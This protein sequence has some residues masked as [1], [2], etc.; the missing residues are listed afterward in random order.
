MSKIISGI[1]K[2]ENL[3]NGKIYIG[4]TCNFKQRKSDHYKTLRGNKHDNPHLQNAWNKYGEKNFKFE[5]VEYVE[6]I[7]ESLVEREQYWINKLNVC[8]RDK[9][10]NILPIAGTT[11]GRVVSEET[12]KKL[13]ESKKGII[14]TPETRKKISKANSGKVFTDEHKQKLREANL[15]KIVSEETKLK[16]S[17]SRKG[18]TNGEQINTCKLT[19]NDVKDIKFL[20][21]QGNTLRSIAEKYNVSIGTI[22]SIKQGRNWS[23]ISIE[24]NPEYDIT[25]SKEKFLTKLTEDDVI[26]IKNMIADGLSYTYI[27]NVFKINEVTIYKIRNNK[28]W[29]HITIERNIE[30]S[31][32]NAYK[33]S[34]EDVIKIKQ[35]LKDKILVSKIANMFSV[36]KNTIYNIKNGKI[37]N[38]INIDN[39]N[40]EE[41]VN[42]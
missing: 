41:C 11:L 32:Y 37:Y 33:L 8:N 28:I 10:Y 26:K 30:K 9:G 13:S 23:H 35:M 3:I 38:H 2:I 36:H 15:G 25:K 18:K 4:S 12:K 17:L 5:V 42:Q 27:A 40:F 22:S 39:K 16:M 1:Y 24:E 20:L 19:E 7:A 31:K 21:Y 6:S 14:I 29:S 34:K